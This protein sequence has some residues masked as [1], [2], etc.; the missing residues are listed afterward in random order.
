MV[1]AS[2][3][4]LKAKVPNRTM[5][6]GKPASKV[7]SYDVAKTPSLFIVGPWTNT[8]INFKPRS[9]VAQPKDKNFIS[10]CK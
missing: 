7:D 5:Y 4:W 9:V 3:G 1:V 2:T 8:P 6:I 10:F